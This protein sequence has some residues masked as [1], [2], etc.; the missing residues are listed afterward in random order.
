[1]D[2]DDDDIVDKVPLLLTQKSPDNHKKDEQRINAVKLHRIP[3]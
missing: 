2:R 1:M 3:K